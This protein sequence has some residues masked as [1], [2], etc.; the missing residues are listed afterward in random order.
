MA[1]MLKGIAWS[2]NIYSGLLK[3]WI[4]EEMMSRG[5]L[6]VAFVRISL[7]FVESCNKNVNSEAACIQPLTFDRH[8][9]RL[10][11]DLKKPIFHDSLSR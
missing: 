8:N 4:F 5:L 11:K 10:V 1:M 3:V 2:A 9:R 7:D 6:T